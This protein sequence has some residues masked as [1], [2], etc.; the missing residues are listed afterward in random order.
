[1]INK[2]CFDYKANEF[3]TNIVEYFKLIQNYVCPVCGNGESK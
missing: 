1:M 2:C 3:P